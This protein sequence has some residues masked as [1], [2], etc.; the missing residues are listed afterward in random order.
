MLTFEAGQVQTL[1]RNAES[2]FV[3][4]LQEH[5]E[6]TY[7]EKTRALGP[8]TTRTIVESEFAA[9]REH[10]FVTERQIAS[11]VGLAFHTGS[12]LGRQDWAQPIL[13]D[14]SDPERRVRRLQAAALETKGRAH[15]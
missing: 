7:P 13:K 5:V 10:G 8:R 11:Y 4:R 14:D 15:A 9:A 3:D 1:A 6:A 2:D 12:G